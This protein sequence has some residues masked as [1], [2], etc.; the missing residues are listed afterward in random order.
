[1]K[2][3]KKENGSTIM[4]IS[5]SDA[6]VLLS[7]HKHLRPE[8]FTEHGL[9][10]MRP[11]KD[12]FIEIRNPLNVH[13]LRCMDF[14]PAADFLNNLDAVLHSKLWDKAV[15]DYEGIHFLLHESIESGVP[16]TQEQ[17]DYL[18]RVTFLES[19]MIAKITNID[20]NA[21]GAYDIAF[22]IGNC[23]KLQAQNYIDS[24]FVCYEKKARVTPSAPTLVK[25]YPTF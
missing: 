12:G 3:V 18:N 21:E 17:V 22:E 2:T 6:K 19:G 24:I 15:A 11:N 1:M 20:F 5:E 16:F 23:L 9:I 10:T 14:I 8:L 4:C 7:M 13:Y 25:K